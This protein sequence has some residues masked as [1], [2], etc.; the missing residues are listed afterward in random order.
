[1]D[2]QIPANGGISIGIKRPGSCQHA[3]ETKK[4]DH[5]I[6]PTEIEIVASEMQQLHSNTKNYVLY[7]ADV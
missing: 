6:A 4:C 3:G 1:M 7:H 2:D 5:T